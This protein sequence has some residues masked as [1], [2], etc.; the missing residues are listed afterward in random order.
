MTRRPMR[1]GEYLRSDVLAQQWGEIGQAL[2][3][4]LSEKADSRLNEFLKS[5]R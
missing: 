1:G 5:P 3:A 2:E 4:E